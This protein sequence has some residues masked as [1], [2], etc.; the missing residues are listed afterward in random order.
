MQTLDRNC[1]QSN[2]MT[3]CI[4]KAHHKGRHYSYINKLYH[5]PNTCQFGLQSDLSNFSIILY[6]CMVIKFPTLSHP[7]WDQTSEIGCLAVWVTSLGL[8][9]FS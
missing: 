5:L 4:L 2:K 1:A 8:V 7:S 9:D 6:F 3:Q